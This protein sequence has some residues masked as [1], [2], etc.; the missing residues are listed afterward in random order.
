MVEPTRPAGSGNDQTSSMDVRLGLSDPLL[1]DLKRE[2][3]TIA[4]L[5]QG[6]KKRPKLTHK[7]IFE[8]DKGLDKMLKTFP[9]IKLKGKGQEYE[10]LSL[11]L[12]HYRKWFQELYPYGEHFEDI[13]M[14]ARQ[15]LQDKE[16][17][18]DGHVSDP[19]EMLHTFRLQYKSA[20]ARDSGANLSDDQKARIEANRARALEVKRKKEAEAGQAG[21]EMDMEE[22]WRMEEEYAAASKP[23]PSGPPAFGAFDEDEDVF[24]Y[25]GFD[26]DDGPR[27]PDIPVS[28]PTTH[29]SDDVRARIEANRKRALEIKKQKEAQTNKTSTTENQEES[30][31]VQALE[32]KEGASIQTNETSTTENQKTL[33]PAVNPFDEE[34]DVFGYGGAFDDMDDPGGFG[35]FD[36]P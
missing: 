15:V 25:G 28:A 31:E 4:E 29:V 35:G 13:V 36:D 2:G 10:D 34:E 22:I 17:D 16:K 32:L 18:D 21:Q 14:K 27:A 3:K 33:A 11:L 1:T 26:E 19:R 24:G 30:K 20:A 9:K 23:Q 12:Q 6:P 8:D 5:Q 7:L